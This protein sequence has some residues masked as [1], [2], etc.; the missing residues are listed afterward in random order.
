MYIYI[1]THITYITCICIFLSIKKIFEHLKLA[2]DPTPAK[3]EPTLSLKLRNAMPA[4]QLPPGFLKQG[5]PNSWMV[6]KV[7]N[8]TIK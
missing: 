5:Y 8:P 1:Y 7:G 3:L 6:E 2:T 4:G